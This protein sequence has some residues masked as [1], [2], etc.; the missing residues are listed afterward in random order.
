MS[1]GEVQAQPS[2][3][4]P[5]LIQK[6]QALTRVQRGELAKK[7][8]DSQIFKQLGFKD[9]KDA[10]TYCGVVQKA[11]LEKNTELTGFAPNINGNGMEQEQALIKSKIDGCFVQ[12]PPLVEQGYWSMGEFEELAKKYT[13]EFL[14][15]HN[16]VQADKGQ[17]L[18]QMVTLADRVA[19]TVLET[20]SKFIAEEMRKR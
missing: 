10:F 12:L 4:T 15:A 2:P 17:K 14:A 18:G 5:E 3:L 11:R 8:S 20:S 19:K 16:N 1:I 7:Y 13:S 9:G 6:F